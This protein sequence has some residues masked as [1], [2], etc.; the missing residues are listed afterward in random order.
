MQAFQGRPCIRREP[1]GQALICPAGRRPREALSAEEIKA[2]SGSRPL[3]LWFRQRGSVWGPSRTAPFHVFGLI[4]PDPE[5]RF[6]GGPRN[7]FPE[8]TPSVDS[9]WPDPCGTVCRL[10]IDYTC[11]AEQPAS[12]PGADHAPTFSEPWGPPQQ[13]IT[14]RAAVQQTRQET[15]PQPGP[16]F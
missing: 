9:R 8:H 10:R 14:T 5:R 15:T 3:L 16:I 11:S 12:C 6:P 1:E 2:R 13:T 4:I 7:H